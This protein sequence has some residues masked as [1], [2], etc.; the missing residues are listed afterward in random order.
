[1][2]IKPTL[3]S[4]LRAGLFAT[5]LTLTTWSHAAATITPLGLQPGTY[6]FTMKGCVFFVLDCTGVFQLYA[7]PADSPSMTPPVV[8]PGAA[9]VVTVAGWDAISV[10]VP[11]TPEVRSDGGSL[12]QILRFGTEAVML[13]S[14]ASTLGGPGMPRQTGEIVVETGP[15]P[16]ST[17]A[18]RFVRS[19]LFDELSIGVTNPTI[20]QGYYGPSLVNMSFKGGPDGV[21][22][23]STMLFNGF[24]FE[25]MTGRLFYGQIGT[26]IEPDP[27]DDLT[28]IAR[29]EAFR[30]D[31]VDFLARPA[32]SIT[33][34]GALVDTSLNPFSLV[35]RDVL[36][37]T[38]RRIDGGHA[39]WDEVRRLPMRDDLATIVRELTVPEPA[40]LALVV[41][42]LATLLAPGVRRRARPAS[43]SR[44]AQ[45]VVG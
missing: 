29:L 31:L 13:A 40:S 8:I 27:A 17:P 19:D 10:H 32:A 21:L 4:L 5:G 23:W 7:V 9:P 33:S 24:E 16:G 38:L 30:S 43:P 35:S 37:D 22:R 1:M 45:P 6:G 34:I 20:F 36:I 41:A 26:T 2:N 44:P 25:V 11:A 3:R 18:Q 15:F 14:T 12:S 39:N 28:D 42:G